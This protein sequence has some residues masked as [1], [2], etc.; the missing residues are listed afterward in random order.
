MKL[1]TFAASALAVLM[2]FAGGAKNGNAPTLS[3]PVPGEATIVQNMSDDGKWIIVQS[4]VDNDDGNAHGNGGTLI[5]VDNSREKYTITHPSGF[6]LLGDVS[7]GGTIVAGCV[8]NQPAFWTRATGEW[9]VTK[10]PKGYAV[11][12]LLAITPDGKYAVGKMSADPTNIT[13]AMNYAALMVDL[14]T[15]EVVE[16]K[17]L[18]TIDM[19]GINQNE[20]ALRAISPDGRYIVG[21]L[22]YCY[23]GETVAYIYD[24]Q[25][26]TFVYPG[27]ELTGNRLKPL[28]TG[29]HH[30]DVSTM[31]PNGEWVAGP[32][33]MVKP[34]AG[35][36]YGD[37]YYCTYRYHIPTGKYEVYDGTYDHDVV[38]FSISNEGTVLAA[39]PFENPYSA[40]MIRHGNYYYPMSDIYKQVYEYDFE[41]STGYAVTGKPINI[42]SDGKTIVMMPSNYECYIMHLQ[43]PLEDVCA[44]IDLLGNY[45]VTPAEGS[46][47]SRLNT[48][49]VNFG[50]SID[51]YGNASDI[52]L[53]DGQGNQLRTALSSSTKAD[54]STLTIG[55]RAT[56]LENGQKYTVRIPAN[57]VSLKDDREMSNKE[58][59][60]SY[61]G[62]GDKPVALQATAPANGA[63]LSRLD[64]TTS[65]ILMQ[66]DSQVAINPD[67]VSS[68]VLR[69]IGDTPQYICNLN[70]AA[71][72]NQVLVYP[73]AGQY[74]Y[75]GVEYEVSIPAGAIT[76]VSGAPYTASEAI[77]LHFT[78]SYERELNTDGR[79]IFNDVCDSFTNWMIYEGDGNNPGGVPTLWGFTADYPWFPIREDEV[80]EEW[81]FASHSMYSPAGKSDDWLSTPQLFIPDDKCVLTFDSQSYR[82]A[83]QDRLKVMVLATDNIY[84]LLSAEAVKEFRDKGDVVYDEV[85]SP[86]SSEEFLAGDWTHNTV[87]LSKYA[88]KNVYIA[89][90]NENNDQSAV[91]LDNVQVVHDTRFTAVFEN[92]ERVVAQDNIKISGS[93]GITSVAETFHSIKLALKDAQGQQID[94]IEQNAL[95]LKNGDVYPFAFANPLPLQKGEENR[96]SVD[97]T[98]GDETASATSSVKNL[99][100]APIQRV[101]LEEY[102][103]SDCGNCPL[104]IRAI[105]NLESY[106]PGLFIPITLRCYGGDY[107]GNGVTNYAAFLG[108]QAAPTGMINRNGI[109]SPMV[110]NG[111]DYLFSGAGLFDSDGVEQLVWLDYVQ[112]EF[113]RGTDLNVDLS[114]NY[115]ADAK[116]FDATVSVTPALSLQSQDLRV[117]MV[118]TEDNLETYQANY[119]ASVVSANIGEWGKGGKYGQGTVYPY[120]AM[121][122]ARTCYG[123]TFAGT[124]GLLPSNLAAGQTYTANVQGALPANVEVPENCK[125][126]AMI[127]D[128]NSQRVVNSV[129]L[130][131]LSGNTSG[132]EDIVGDG[133]A[134][135]VVEVI[136]GQ[137]VIAAEGAFRAEVYNV[138]GSL[139]EA[140]EAQG[141]ASI[142]AEGIHGV[143]IVRITTAQA[144]KI[145]KV[146]L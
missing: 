51:L 29:L 115:D 123:T 130:N 82:K 65:P 23:M 134:N 90:I 89:F 66:F 25:T 95:N 105:E 124:N 145:V 109:T 3:L 103:G 9:T 42:S 69:S 137:I 102:T 34:V 56:D 100:F 13:D 113:T 141:S 85:Q 143:A 142:D 104:G 1:R 91:F 18:P 39:T 136:D 72:A 54:A 84:Q 118:L 19:S 78:G 101:V 14:T 35:S 131:G 63:T 10:L 83:K 75:K 112:Q 2:A 5:S 50:R 22:S 114:S 21:D 125:L 67:L 73:T 28:A 38:V 76:D 31:S 24:C 60:I 49:S 93:V 77:T 107:L 99:V 121:D 122:V 87:S 33:Y 40:M 15:N 128:G 70:L 144:T 27:F 30:S 64:M 86:G 139:V 88:G 111:S 110:S 71:A 41:A 43:E 120:T 108:L 36:E 47:F 37:E 61:T 74:L 26:A 146:V 81:S 129:R 117:F 6:V 119:L 52:Q 96:F 97:V 59:T 46:T 135:A 45:T 106:F 44:G 138:A 57:M 79:Y 116:T 58:I 94:V 92:P 17:N 4:V 32:A 126:T 127:I 53:L 11:G 132:V 55:F 12:Q 98:L 80:A 7:D 20:N 62:R 140:V 48:V 8:N 16:L 133:E 68:S